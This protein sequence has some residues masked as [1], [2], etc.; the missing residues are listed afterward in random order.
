LFSATRPDATAAFDAP[1]PIVFGT[2]ANSFGDPSFSPDAKTLYFASDL[3]GGLGDQD[4]WMATRD[5]L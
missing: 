2:Q 5:C 1:T 4:L 3:A